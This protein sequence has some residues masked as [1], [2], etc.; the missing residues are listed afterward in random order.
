MHHFNMV[1]REKD[2]H[3]KFDFVLC[4]I[5]TLE[6]GEP[7][8]ILKMSSCKNTN[9]HE[10][11]CRAGRLSKTLISLYLFLKQSIIDKSQYKKN[12]FSLNFFN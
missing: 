3:Q 4:K 11:I 5:P 10:T 12:T 8:K 6:E 2:M 9:K 1:T 7:I